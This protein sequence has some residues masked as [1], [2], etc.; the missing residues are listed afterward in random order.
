MLFCSQSGGR[1]VR[2]CERICPRL[3]NFECLSGRRMALL[4]PFLAYMQSL[5]RPSLT[6]SQAVHA[7]RTKAVV[8]MWL[9]SQSHF[10]PCVIRVI[11]PQTLNATVF[12][13][14]SR[15][16]LFS[17]LICASYR[18]VFQIVTEVLEIIRPFSIE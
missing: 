14:I 6:S 15:L 9:G 10:S 16:Q 8:N 12:T 11:L 18:H 13:K 5:K 17:L 4:L 3:Q 7:V 1:E 2:L